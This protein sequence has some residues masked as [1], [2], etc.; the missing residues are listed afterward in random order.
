MCIAGKRWVGRFQRLVR[1]DLS[2]RLSSLIRA[3]QMESLITMW[4]RLSTAAD[5]K[6]L[7]PTKPKPSFLGDLFSGASSQLESVTPFTI[8]LLC[9]SIESIP[10]MLTATA[11]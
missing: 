4:P 11:V 7:I 3:S 10:E 2:L 1:A 9:E 6:A 8:A 5:E